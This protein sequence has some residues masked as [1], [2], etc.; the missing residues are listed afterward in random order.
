MAVHID[1]LDP[2]LRLW[3]DFWHVLYPCL[4][5]ST[6]AVAGTWLHLFGVDLVDPGQG[7][8]LEMEAI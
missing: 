6:R 3:I 7:L 5:T 4:G 8:V 1:P 2:Y